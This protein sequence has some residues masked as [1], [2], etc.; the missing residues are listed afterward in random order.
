MSESP[1]DALMPASARRVV[2]GLDIGAIVECQAID[3]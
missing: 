2:A 1:Q 3:A